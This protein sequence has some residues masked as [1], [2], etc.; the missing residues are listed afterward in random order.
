MIY[1]NTYTFST[2]WSCDKI[3]LK[4]REHK[5]TVEW[6]NFQLRIIRLGEVTYSSLDIK[7]KILPYWTISHVLK[8]RVNMTTNN[9]MYRAEDGIVMVHPPNIPFYEKNEQAGTHQYMFFDCNVATHQALF[10]L[11]PLYPAIALRDPLNYAMMFRSIHQYWK[12]G[13]T[14]AAD[15]IFALL[16]IPSLLQ[17]LIEDWHAMGSPVRPGY[18]KNQDPRMEVLIEYMQHHLASPITRETLAERL[19]LH[20]NYLDRIFMKQYQ[21]TPMLMLRQLRMEKAKTMLT[22]TDETTESIAM[23]CGFS[24]AS[25]FAKLFKQELEETPGQ[26]RRKSRVSESLYSY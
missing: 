14:Q 22:Q 20:P 15:R 3:C 5:L 12:Q 7:N 8:G 17:I 2:F 18:K 24:S 16:G 26:F 10:D 19:H 6:N 21:I 13:E 1:T 9:T 11:L 4:V 23:A 25:H